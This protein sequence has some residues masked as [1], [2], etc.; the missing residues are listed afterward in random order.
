MT[1]PDLVPSRETDKVPSSITSRYPVSWRSTLQ[2]EDI[3]HIEDHFVPGLYLPGKDNKDRTTTEQD[4]EVRTRVSC[5]SEDNTGIVTMKTESE[6]KR[7]DRVG[8]EVLVDMCDHYLVTSDRTSSDT[9]R[10]SGSYYK[11]FTSDSIIPMVNNSA[12][13]MLFS[14]PS[15]VFDKSV[16]PILSCNNESHRDLSDS[17]SPKVLQYSASPMVQSDST[18]GISDDLYKL[19]GS[20]KY[21]V[22][23]TNQQNTDKTKQDQRRGVTT[24]TNASKNATVRKYYLTIIVLLYIGNTILYFRLIL[25]RSNLRYNFQ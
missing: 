24:K 12:S 23:D 15:M 16:S 3:L 1:R 4:R 6:E 20:E 17:L 14:D 21:P 8:E 11:H 18:N 7:S 9:H 10:H 22:M 13:S 19:R 5:H 25:M 2:S